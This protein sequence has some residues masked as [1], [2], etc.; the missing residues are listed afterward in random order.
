MLDSLSENLV[1]NF[2]L[3]A[4]VSAFSI[5]WPYVTFSGL[6]NFI[7][8]LSVF[9]RKKL[10]RIEVAPPGE[11]MKVCKTFITNTNDLF[12]VIRQEKYFKLITLNLDEINE[13]ENMG[14]S[15][16]ERAEGFKF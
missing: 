16:E 7:M 12:V 15:L 1:K 8:L 3:Y 14:K 9:D 4:S 13:F 11:A 5:K 6:E 2:Y 10:H